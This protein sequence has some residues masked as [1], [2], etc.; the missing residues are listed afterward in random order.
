MEKLKLSLDGLVVES[1]ATRRETGRRGTV[2]GNVCDTVE[3]DCTM[4]A[5]T[6]SGGG[7]A[8]LD[9]FYCDGTVASAQRTRV[10]CQGTANCGG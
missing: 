10:C 4:L 2:R 5:E 9:P 8:T 1:F 6:C 7:H 3:F